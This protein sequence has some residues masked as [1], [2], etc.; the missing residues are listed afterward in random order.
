[1]KSL[2][3]NIRIGTIAIV[4]IALT[5]LSSCK[6]EDRLNPNNPS[7]QGALSN[8]TVDELNNIVIGTLSGMRNGLGTYYDNV[9]VVGREIYRFSGSDPRFTSDLLGAGNAVLDNNTFYTTIPW[10]SRYRVIKNTN[11]LIGSV[12]NT[13]FIT[14]QQRQGYLGFANTIKA[15]ELLMVLNLTDVNGIRIE[16]SDPRNLGPIVSKT[17]AL[18]AIA[19]LLETANQQLG[20]AGNSFAF[21]LT[22]GFSGFNTP[23]TFRQFNRALAARVALYRGNFQEA[24]NFLNAS[25]FNLNGSTQTGVYHVFSNAAGDQL[26]PVF[27]PPNATGEVRVAQPRFLTDA[28]NAGEGND[29]RLT[30]ISLRN[31]PA[32]QSSLT[33]THD[34]AIY[35]SN[36]SPITIIRNEELIL[37]NAEANIRIGAANFPAAVNALNNIRQRYGLP[38]YSGPLTEPALIDEMLK[39]RRYS[40]YMEGHRWID[41]RR[42]NRL[43]QLPIDRANDDVWSNFP[44]PFSENAN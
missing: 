33:G 8:A 32:T 40:L 18:T 12:A 44:I 28:Q 16:V 23:A 19:G 24:L 42:Y 43:N 31:S 41:M 7:L 36:L 22:P 6:I 30:K 27:F 17:A 38:A 26:N 2:I 13:N 34:L 35:P 5:Q 1:M 25:F 9:G 39:Q 3:K 10:A 37:I 4:A 20:S 11:I 29:T 21:S 15:Y 14:E